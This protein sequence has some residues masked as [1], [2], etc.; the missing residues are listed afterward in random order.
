MLSGA[1]AA[2]F[3]AG[4]LVGGIGG[5][6]GMF[7]LR[8]TS[9]PSLHGLETDDGFTIGIFSGATLFLLLLTAVLGA[10]G[11]LVYV[12]VRPWL[13]EAARPWLFDGLAGVVGGAAVSVPAVSTSRSCG[14]TG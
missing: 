14:R 7:V 6:L 5:R 12:I 10:A 11:G 4:G 9:N 2:G 13:P 3:L 8:L 1:A